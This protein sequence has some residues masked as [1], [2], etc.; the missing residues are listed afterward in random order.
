[1]DSKQKIPFLL[2]LVSLF[3]FLTLIQD[4]YAKY[5]SN[6]DASTN[7]TIARWNIKINNQDIVNNNNFSDNIVPVF[8]GNDYIAQDIIAPTSEG[9]F[10]LI[11]DYSNVDVAFNKTISINP[12]QDNTIE[13]LKITGYSVDGEE[14]IHFTDTTI[15]TNSV[16]LNQTNK[17]QTY[18]IYI[19]WIDD[20]NE[21]M[22]NEDDTN[23]TINGM[24]TINVN[25][26]F[27][28]SIS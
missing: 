23:A 21:I 22:T 9:Y 7:L 12:G 10:D 8:P 3:I 16:E 20:E 6:A 11:I 2:A 27:I 26:S 15:I 25:V 17:T 18:R 1:V 28:Q 13:D 5:V 14:L 19:K 4:S 24:A